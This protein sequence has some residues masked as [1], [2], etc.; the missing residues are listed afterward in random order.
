MFGVKA[1]LQHISNIPCRCTAAHRHI[2]HHLQKHLL[3]PLQVEVLCSDSNQPLEFYSTLGDQP[4]QL[5]MP[6]ITGHQGQEGSTAPT[7][8]L[9][10]A[11]C[12]QASSSTAAAAPAADAD[13]LAS[14]A[15]DAAAAKQEQQ[16]QQAVLSS[17]SGN[18]VTQL[19]AGGNCQF[20]VQREAG[21][22]LL[23]VE[24]KPVGACQRNACRAISLLLG[25]PKG[26]ST[27][28]EG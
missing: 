27:L 11:A 2:L 28:T 18:S 14:A 7:L 1:V 17:S 4:L 5:S 21:S 10:L 25:L 20:E 16:Q 3:L 23:K 9:N 22:L 26:Q 13:G 12:L 19:L 15:G 6:H 8:Q 24:G